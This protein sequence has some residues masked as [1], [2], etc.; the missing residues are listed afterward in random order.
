MVQAL[1]DWLEKT[2]QPAAREILGEDIIRLESV[3]GYQCRNRAHTTRLSE[4][5]IANA[6]DILGFVT[7]SGHTITVLDSWG[8]TTRDAPEP[9]PNE[10]PARTPAPG[11]PPLPRPNPVRTAK[12]VPVMSRV[13]SKPIR[14]AVTHSI[15]IPAEQFLKRVHERSCD[16]FK[17]VLGPDANE[18][19]R[20]HFHLDLAERKRGAHYCR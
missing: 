12:L 7:R 18:D 4:H 5:A 2:V 9:A 8:P 3:A 1:Y 19:H 16:N 6:I 15:S 20:N 11:E 17:T 14:A 13:A 10:P